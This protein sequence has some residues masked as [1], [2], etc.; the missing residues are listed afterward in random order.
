M[1]RILAGFSWVC[2]VSAVIGDVPAALVWFFGSCLGPH[3]R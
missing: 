2:W 1:S 3:Q